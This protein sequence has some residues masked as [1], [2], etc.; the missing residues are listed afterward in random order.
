M[1]T[2]ARQLL[3]L[4]PLLPQVDKIYEY[5]SRSREADAP[6][7]RYDVTPRRADSAVTQRGVYLREPQ[8]ARLP[9]TV[10][11][12]VQLCV[13]EVHQPPHPPQRIMH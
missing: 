7:V 10:Q 1:C 9:I 8:D 13:N 11:V 6:D 4:R 3:N 2:P 5:L 12:C